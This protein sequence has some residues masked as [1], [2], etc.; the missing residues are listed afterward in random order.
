MAKRFVHVLSSVFGFLIFAVALWIIW[1]QLRNY[2]LVDVL[3]DLQLI[4][5]HRFLF[6]LF[7]IAVDYVVL[8][9]FEILSLKYIGKHL[10]YT[11]TAVASFIG[12]TYSANI[13][14]LTGSAIRYR[15]YATWG[16]TAMEVTT[17]V[18][19]CNLTFV[20]GYMMLAGVIFSIEPL[21]I[22]AI[23]HI[24]FGSVRPLGLMFLVLIAGYLLWNIVR[25]EPLHVLGHALP[26]TSLRLSVQ[27]ILLSSLE[28]ILA[29]TALYLLLPASP[30]LGYVGFVGFYL[31]AQLAG[32]ASQAP[33]GIGV[34]EAVMLLLLAHVYPSATLLGILIAYR[35]MYYFLPLGLATIILGINEYHAHHRGHKSFFCLHRTHCRALAQSRSAVS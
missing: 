21:E 1:Y 12:H 11:K 22:P 27:Q 8:T 23:L 24:P 4:P 34:F 17:M 35:V 6:S 3:A 33:A 2:H 15:V 14:L 9:G 32:Q 16:L 5:P 26:R 19:F 30:V 18:L 29:S 10:S 7:V 31:L 20:L 28:W 25:K 13:N